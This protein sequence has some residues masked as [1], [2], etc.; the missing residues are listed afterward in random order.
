MAITFDGQCLSHQNMWS[1]WLWL[2]YFLRPQWRTFLLTALA[3]AFWVVLKKSMS[4]HYWWL[5]EASLLQF[6]DAWWC[7]DTLACG[8][9]SDHHSLIFENFFRWMIWLSTRMT[10]LLCK[11]KVDNT[12]RAKNYQT[13]QQ[14][15]LLLK[16]WLL[17][18]ISLKI[19]NFN[20]SHSFLIS[21][22]QMNFFFYLFVWNVFKAKFAN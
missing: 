9:P 19:N 15:N 21:I 13:Y 18:K 10:L 6:E 4:H 14:N 7:P 20:F 1:T 5:Y 16:N 8:T 11:V 12:I 22:F 17:E 3:F 2:F